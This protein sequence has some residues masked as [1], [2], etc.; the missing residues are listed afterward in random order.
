MTPLLT[1]AYWPN[2]HYFYYLLN[3]DTIVIEQHEHYQ[4]QSFR[5][6]THLLTANGVIDLS[7]PVKKNKI[8][9]FTADIEISYTENWQNKHW[10]AITSAYSNSPYFE[11]F[12]DEIYFFYQSPFKK[13][14]DF[15]TQ[16]LLLLFKLLKLKKEIQFTRDFV[17]QPANYYDAREIIHPKKTYSVD[18]NVVNLLSVPYYQTFGAKFPFQPNLSVLDLLFNTGMGAV[19]YLK[20]E[21]FNAG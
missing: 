14:L 16:Q 3:S 15:N 2:L 9:E 8:K 19:E 21:N 11:Y 12:E 13:L 7:V 6:R 5:N 20:A 17:K 10:R 18:T 4:K 1:T